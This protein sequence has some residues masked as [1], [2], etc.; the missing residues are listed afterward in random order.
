MSTPITKAYD[1]VV[2]CD[3]TNVEQD[4]PMILAAGMLLAAD[5]DAAMTQAAAMPRVEIA[6]KGTVVVKVRRF[7]SCED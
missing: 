3:T 5:R 6:C 4:P 7:I 2:Y 1:Y